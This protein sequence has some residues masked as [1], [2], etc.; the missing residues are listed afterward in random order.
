MDFIELMQ[1]FGLNVKAETVTESFNDD[2]YYIVNKK[3]KKVV[4][5]L[6]KVKVAFGSDPKQNAVIKSQLTSPDLDVVKGMAAKHANYV[7]ENMDHNALLQH[8]Q[9]GHQ[10]ALKK[11][12]ARLAQHYAKRMAFHTRY[13]K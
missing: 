5:N 8:A 2:D 10:R 9:K 6:G 11:G 1:S 12:N 3:T 13:V 7:N 4:K